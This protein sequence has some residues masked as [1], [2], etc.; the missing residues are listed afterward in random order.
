ML[1]HVIRKEHDLGIVAG[2]S[3]C[4]PAVKDH[5][6]RVERPVRK[7][8][9]AQRPA[10]D[11]LRLRGLRMT[12]HDPISFVVIGVGRRIGRTAMRRTIQ[13]TVLAEIDARVNLP[14]RVVSVRQ[15]EQFSEI[16]QLAER[17]RF[18]I[19]LKHEGI[20]LGSQMIADGRVVF[21]VRKR[22]VSPI[23][24][25]PPRIRLAGEVREVD[26]RRRL[27]NRD[28]VQQRFERL[29]EFAR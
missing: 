24:P 23:R 8:A 4:R 28:S 10:S 16:Q 5:S 14:R 3:W 17:L 26:G 22:T 19:V 29:Q 18:R 25:R 7:T 6:L 20:P 27:R 13:P 21:A 11:D 12:A 15:C 2:V 9:F 1:S